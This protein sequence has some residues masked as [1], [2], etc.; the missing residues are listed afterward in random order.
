[1]RF[2]KS[3]R[4]KKIGVNGASLPFC[5]LHRT[6]DKKTKRLAGICFVRWRDTTGRQAFHFVMIVGGTHLVFACPGHLSAAYS[7]SSVQSSVES[8]LESPVLLAPSST[9][10]TWTLLYL[11]FVLFLFV[12]SPH[13]LAINRYA[14]TV[15]SRRKKVPRWPYFYGSDV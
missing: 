10:S 11:R 12:F 14:S 3:A 6:L 4:I 2:F 8:F 5:L 9:E 7:R 15:S 13:Y 1:M